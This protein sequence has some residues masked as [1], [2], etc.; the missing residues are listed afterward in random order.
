VLN[1]VV[2]ASAELYY[3]TKEDFNYQMTKALGNL[4]AAKVAYKKTCQNMEQ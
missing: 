1:D 4:V 3:L 2:I